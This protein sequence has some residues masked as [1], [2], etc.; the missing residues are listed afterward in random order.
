[1]MS[2][3]DRVD[4]PPIGLIGALPALSPQKPNSGY[5]VVSVSLKIFNR[6]I[7]RGNKVSWAFYY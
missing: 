7:S 4:Y 1:M 5:F 3:I 6:N 2:T